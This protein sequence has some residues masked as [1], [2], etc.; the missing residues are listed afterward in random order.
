MKTTYREAVRDVYRKV[1]GAYSVV[2]YIAGHG[3]FEELSVRDGFNPRLGVVAVLA[4]PRRAIPARSLGIL[5]GRQGLLHDFFDVDVGPVGNG[6]SK[7]GGHM[8][9][10]R[11]DGD[12]GCGQGRAQVF[13]PLDGLG[14]RHVGEPDAEPPSTE[15]RQH[16]GLR[17][18]L[19]Q[20]VGDRTDDRVAGRKT[21][22]EIDQLEEIEIHDDAR[23]PIV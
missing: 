17:N 1:R 2:G 14:L 7:A 9:E 12:L 4:E 22:F 11:A 13:C 6:N 19:P 3:L 8:Q 21:V 10:V 23:A 18:L 20:I 5:K 16:V 15:A